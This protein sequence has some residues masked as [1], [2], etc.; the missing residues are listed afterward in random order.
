MSSRTFGNALQYYFISRFRRH[1]ALRK[2]RIAELKT[3]AD[4]GASQEIR[5]DK[6]PH[7][8][9]DKLRIAIANIRQKILHDERDM[10]ITGANDHVRVATVS[11]SDTIWK[12]FKDALPQLLDMI[13]K[14]EE[15]KE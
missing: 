8:G 12:E 2:K 7:I 15:K 9:S 5:Y 3:F 10:E 14:L 1:S 13:S 11:D 4:A 6:R